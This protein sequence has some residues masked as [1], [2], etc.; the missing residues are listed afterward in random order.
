MLNAMQRSVTFALY[1]FTLALGILLMPVALLARR[2]GLHL[3]VDRAV[4]ATGAAYERAG[5][6]ARTN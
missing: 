6:N 1:Q 5:G 3:P 2:A 4:E